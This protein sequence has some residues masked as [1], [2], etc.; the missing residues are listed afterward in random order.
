LQQNYANKSLQQS[1]KAS[2][3]KSMLLLLFISVHTN[4]WAQPSRLVNSSLDAVRHASEH[5]ILLPFSLLIPTGLR[6]GY[7]MRDF[8]AS[9]EFA[10]FDSSNA[11]EVVFDEIY[12]SALEYAH[13]NLGEALLSAAFGS[14]EHEYIPIAF[15]GSEIRIP[16]TSE[17]HQRFV[18][19]WSHIPSHLYHTTE[20]DRDKLQHFFA[21]AWLKESLGMDWLARVAGKMV[22]V[23]ES[24]FVVGG[25]EDPRDLHANHDGIHFAI[26]ASGNLGYPPSKALTPNPVK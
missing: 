11:P 1:V 6:E 24:L 10:A 2:V 8:I 12:Y 15:F 5:S 17:D 7:D 19:R 26:E 13:G 3:R 9:P 18:V 23:G 21:S 20:V 25:S 4:A 16:L 22:E 14:I